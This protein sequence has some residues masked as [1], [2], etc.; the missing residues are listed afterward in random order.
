MQQAGSHDRNKEGKTRPRSKEEGNIS[1]RIRKSFS[2]FLG[3]PREEADRDKESKDDK[4]IFEVSSPQNQSPHEFRTI[5]T[6]ALAYNMLEINRLSTLSAS[7]KSDGS[8][9]TQTPSVESS[10]FTLEP[11]PTRRKELKRRP[12]SMGPTSAEFLRAKKD[13]DDIPLDKQKRSSLGLGEV[14]PAFR[15][16]QSLT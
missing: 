12:K 11:I 10:P 7:N 6:E 1:M 16:P 2:M 13:M 9:G 15:V 3:N 5:G 14:P 4:R 8:H